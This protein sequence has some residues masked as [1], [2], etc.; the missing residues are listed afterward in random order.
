MHASDDIYEILLLTKYCRLGGLV[1]LM[2]ERLNAFA[3]QA[4]S[5]RPL[6][7]EPELLKIFCDICESVG[8]LHSRA[9]IHRDLKIENILIDDTPDLDAN[10]TDK[11][12][13]Q[14]QR[15]MSNSGQ[16]NYNYVLCDFGS[17]TNKVFDRRAHNYCSHQV[18]QIADEIQK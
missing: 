10:L 2:N 6:L 16:P 4:Q 1:Q 11:Q 12:F 9:I 17:A 14:Q 15:K 18:Q 5:S 8:D 13:K 7:T 3:A